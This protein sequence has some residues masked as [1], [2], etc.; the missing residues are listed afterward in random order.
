MFD[1]HSIS[2]HM[3][4]FWQLN[5]ASLSSCWQLLIFSHK[6]FAIIIFIKS[7]HNFC[8]VIHSFFTNSFP[9]CSLGWS[10]F[11]LFQDSIITILVSIRC[12]PPGS[13]ILLVAQPS[14]SPTISISQK[15]NAEANFILYIIFW[16][17]I[18]QTYIFGRSI[19]LIYLLYCVYNCYYSLL[20][21]W[22][23]TLI[24]NDHQ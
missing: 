2:T 18:T 7:L 11:G 1:I 16:G 4:Q 24:C 15:N 23:I 6:N 22:H 10:Q 13:L 9:C 19:F 5:N 12:Y 21:C 8:P 20:R 17:Y 3:I 14:V